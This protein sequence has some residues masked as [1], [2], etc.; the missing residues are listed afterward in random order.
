MR[1]AIGGIMQETNTFLPVPTEVATFESVYLR[2]GEAMLTG[3]GAARVEVPGM[4]AV[5]RAAGV[6]PVPLL[7]TMAGA[8]GA[9]SRAAF[10]ALLGDLLQRLRDAGPVDGVLLALHGAMVLEDQPDAEGELLER[11]RAELPAHVPIGVSLDLHGHITPRMLQPNTFLIGYREYPHIDMYEAGERTA[12]LMLDVLAGRRRPVMALAKKHLLVSPINART[13]T[14]PLSRIVAA[15]RRMEQDGRV[16]HASLFPVQPW[17]D[18]PDLGFCALVCADGDARAAQAA[19]DELAA[20]AWQARDEFTPDLTPL[21]DAIRIGLTSPG[22]TVVGDGGDAP[23]SGAA[24]DNTAVLRALLAAGADRAGRL[25]Y[26]TLCDADAARQ[27]A[28]AGVGA[29][30]TLRV[31]HKMSR[32]GEPLDITGCVRT[33]TDGVFTMHDAGADGTEADMGL[34]AVIAIG[35]IRLAIRSRRFLEW[36]TGLF[37][38]AGLPLRH[39]A[40]VFVKSPSHFRVSYAPHADRVLAADTPDTTTGNMHRLVFKNV[41]RPLYPLDAAAD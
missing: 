41:T 24:A 39:A 6:E 4:L 15:A 1:I 32:D 19:A 16:L 26:L 17:I 34:T 2:R 31:G 14:P 30:V 35:D 10:E 38:S 9:V 25:T 5:L 3:Y 8:A 23:S 22:T 11:V 13:D 29:T 40:L 33:L 21:D 27:A 18:V 12:Q 28:A 36:D 37:T 20:M 7:A